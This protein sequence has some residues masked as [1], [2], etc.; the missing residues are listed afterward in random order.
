MSSDEPPEKSRNM[1]KQKKGSTKKDEAGLMKASLSNRDLPVWVTNTI[2]S[3]CN[4]GR[5]KKGHISNF[6]FGQ[7]M[8]SMSVRMASVHESSQQDSN[9][10]SRERFNP[11]VKSK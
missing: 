11:S 1:H 9:E 2:H 10:E 6:S 4:A 5:V 7:T 3:A 8:R